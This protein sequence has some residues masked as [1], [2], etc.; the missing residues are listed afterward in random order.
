MKRVPL[1]LKRQ[2]TL[3]LLL[4]LF[5]VLAIST[6]ASYYR[7]FHFAN[8][9]YDRSL[10]RAALALADQVDVQGSQVV[11]NLPQVARELLEYDKD[12]LIYYH[13]TAPDGTP[14]LGEPNFPLPKKL[15]STGN[16]L[17]YDFQLENKPVRV[18]A[19]SLPIINSPIQGNILVQVAETRTKRETMV[20]EIVEEMLIPQLLI[21]LLAASLIFIGIKRG[22]L[23]LQH[24]QDAINARSYRDL[25]PIAAE[26]APREIR[27]LL[28]SMNNLMGRVREAAKLQQQFIADA[29]HQMR[30]PIAGL[31]TQAELALREKDPKAIHSTL[32]LVLSSSSRLSHLLSRLLVMASVDPAAGRDAKFNQVNLIELATKV[33]SDFVGNAGRIL[34]ARVSRISLSPVH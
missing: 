23:P 22:L 6:V 31:Q 28:H 24:V 32:E 17:Y 9:A 29:S 13:I 12:D 11:V 21:L 34:I 25:S 7:A 27:P 3:W 19:F 33:S 26:E 16:H 18:V 10:F 1:S 2:L 20:K 30:T 5:V 15:P 8:L 14:V 4:P